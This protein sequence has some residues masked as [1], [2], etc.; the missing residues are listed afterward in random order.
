MKFYH[1]LRFKLLIGILLLC[2]LASIGQSLVSFWSGKTVL[3]TEIT[4]KC[5]QIAESTSQVID[6]YFAGKLEKFDTL[7]KTSLL[8]N[9]REEEI[10]ATLAGIMTSEYDN[11]Y[12]I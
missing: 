11:I 3:T 1:S 6:T 9:M 10:I 8:K 2:F 7:S 4:S 5:Q 12:V